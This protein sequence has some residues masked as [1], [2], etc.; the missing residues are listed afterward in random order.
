LAGGAEVDKRVEGGYW[1][2]LIHA[3]DSI[4]DA[5]V[6]LSRSPDNRIIGLLLENGANVNAESVLGTALKILERYGNHDAEDLLRKA[7]AR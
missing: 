1:T 3:A 4:S 2:P 7:G 6:Q 5:A